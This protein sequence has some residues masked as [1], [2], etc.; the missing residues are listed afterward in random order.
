MRRPGAQISL[1]AR[2][3]EN[4]FH[5]MAYDYFRNDAPDTNYFFNNANRIRRQPSR[6]NNF[7]A[8]RCGFLGACV[9]VSV[10]KPLLPCP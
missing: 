7:G 5:V 1:L 10:E 6:Y 4:R 3:G 2:S 8:R 9:A